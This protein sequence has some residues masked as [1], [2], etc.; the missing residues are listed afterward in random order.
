MLNVYFINL[1]SA[2]DR[3]S[4]LE[5][6]LREMAPHWRIHRIKAVT[7][8]EA[9]LQPPFNAADNSSATACYL[10]HLKAIEAALSSEGPAVIMED[11]TQLGRQSAALI[12]QLLNSLPSES[13]DLLYGSVTYMNLAQT[14]AACRHL[15]EARRTDTIL[16]QNAGEIDF[17]CATTYVIHPKAKKKLLE[18][19]KETPINPGYDF[20]LK[21][22]FQQGL[23]R[24]LIPL[25][26]LTSVSKHSVHS[27]LNQNGWHDQA[28]DIV[29]NSVRKLFFVEQDL[30]EIREDL[31][32]LGKTFHEDELEVFGAIQARLLHPEFRGK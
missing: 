3:R 5:A 18:L 28:T 20:R 12:E 2:T 17:A 32:S 26:F 19:L 7:R 14:Q 10:S 11:D 30:R 29:L 31:N 25:P 9:S 23:L 1:E 6:N 13:W 8:E 15:R 22:I 21:Q 16:L 4:T 24:G 27:Q